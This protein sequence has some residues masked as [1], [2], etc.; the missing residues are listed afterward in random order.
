MEYNSGS[1]IYLQ[2]INELKKKM[3]SE[4]EHS[5]E[6]LPGDGDGR[7]LLHEAWNRYICVGGGV[8]V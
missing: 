7:I 6:N 2:V 5:G 4:S 8:Y 3:V 1:P